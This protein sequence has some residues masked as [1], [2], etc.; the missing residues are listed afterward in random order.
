M[1]RNMFKDFEMGLEPV[2]PQLEHIATNRSCN[3]NS[4]RLE[5]SMDGMLVAT[6]VFSDMLKLKRY[7][8]KSNL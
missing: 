5:L 4:T 7:G 3:H 1:N 8:F 6:S 2:P